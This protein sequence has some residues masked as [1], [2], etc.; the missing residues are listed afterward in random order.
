MKY[1]RPTSP[2]VLTS[3]V[4][5]T[6]SKSQRIQRDWSL[7]LEVLSISVMKWKRKKT[8]RLRFYDSEF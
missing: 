1:P 7:R 3:S 5:M 6:I 2:L 8:A 4:E